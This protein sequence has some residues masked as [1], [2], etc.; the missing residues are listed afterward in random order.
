[1]DQ[2]IKLT[3]RQLQAGS[4]RTGA[5]AFKSGMMSHFD[6]WGQ[7]HPCTVLNVKKTVF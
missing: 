7:R 1:M 3:P 2:S 5:L 4:I 6:E